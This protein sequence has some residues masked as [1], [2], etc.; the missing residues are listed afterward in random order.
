MNT[1]LAHL[2]PL[3]VPSTCELTGPRWNARA[4][5]H[6]ALDEVS[7]N[8]VI[9]SRTARAPVLDFGCGEGLATL[10]ALA[11]GASVFALDED[12]EAVRHLL[13]RVPSQQHPRLRARVG[14][15]LATDFKGV[16]FDALHAARILHEFDGAAVE[17]VLKKFY[18]WLYPNGRLFLSALAPSGAYWR[19][20]EGEYL[21]RC[22]GGARWP[23][24]V[25][26]ASPLTGHPGDAR[27]VH[28]LDEATL[29]RELEAVG[30]QIE[31][32][33][34]LPLPWDDDQISCAVI[35]RCRI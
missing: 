2:E 9:A 27:A 15:L 11:R 35:A 12:E 33:R 34:C 6:R 14:S 25:E 26:Q 13:T 23:G 32:S 22:A 5:L 4:R 19:A 3:G 28:L 17:R 29:R 20:F 31:Q 7:L 10:A 24:Y 1:A 30:F 8:F 16:H 21:K 18:R